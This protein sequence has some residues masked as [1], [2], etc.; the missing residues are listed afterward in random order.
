MIRFEHAAVCG[1]VLLA[2]CQPAP[3]TTSPGA[4]AAPVKTVS[5]VE[6]ALRTVA[7]GG[8]IPADLVVRY[9][10]MHGMHGGSTISLSGS[11]ALQS[12]QVGQNGRTSR[13]GTLSS[14]SVRAIVQLLVELEAWEQR[15]PPRRPVPDESAAGLTIRVA[16]QEARIWE[17]YNEMGANDRLS[18]IFARLR[19]HAGRFPA[20]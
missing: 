16:G 18:R 8:E 9:S 17:W 20:T 12:E 14:D 13:S 1:F 11:G 5:P 10:D 6:V 15:T 4:V 2:A 19:T 3:A 7:A